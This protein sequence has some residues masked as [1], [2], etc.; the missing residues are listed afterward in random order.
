MR[1]YL[2][3]Y[4]SINMYIIININVY[5]KKKCIYIT[6]RCVY[7]KAIQFMCHKNDSY[8]K[9]NYETDLKQTIYTFTV[10]QAISTLSSVKIIVKQQKIY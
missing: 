1:V 6:L 4:K 8:S 3:N 9:I 5:K 10:V 7:I 2:H